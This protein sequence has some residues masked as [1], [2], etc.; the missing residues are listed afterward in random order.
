MFMQTPQFECGITFHS[1]ERAQG[2]IVVTGNRNS[3][4][5]QIVPVDIKG[6]KAGAEKMSVYTE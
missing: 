3:S 6:K 4:Y 5:K 2:L 1:C